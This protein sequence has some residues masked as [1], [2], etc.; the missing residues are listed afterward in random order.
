[1]RGARFSRGFPFVELEIDAGRRA[2]ILVWIAGIWL[3]YATSA[4]ARVFPHYLIVTY[5]VSFAV[6][7]L[8]LS[9]LVSMV[10]NRYRFEAR[11]VAYGVL[12][13]ILAGYV[14]FTLSFDRFLANE[15]G[16]S[17]DYGVVYREK[18]ALARFA[19]ERGLRV[20][21][22]EVL[23]FLVT[24]VLFAPLGT[25]PSLLVRDRLE[26]PTPLPCAIELHRFG[27]LAACPPA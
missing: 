22:D 5:P 19:E 7:G 17:G 1:V 23:D 9:D 14:A 27:P 8:G 2:L 24:D 16:T 21:N 12:A 3:S 10:G 20:A 15:G 13:A 6:M 18:A 11:I 25:E 4:T 26:D